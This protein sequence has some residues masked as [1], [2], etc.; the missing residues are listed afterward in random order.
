MGAEHGLS[1]AQ[2]LWRGTEYKSIPL[3][4]EVPQMLAM[5]IANHCFVQ[6]CISPFLGKSPSPSFSHGV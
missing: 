1:G 2:T 3:F 4:T 5:S 6:R